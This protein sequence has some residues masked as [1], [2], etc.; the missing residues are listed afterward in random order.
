MSETNTPAEL[1][2]DQW[3]PTE[4]FFSTSPRS[5]HIRDLCVNITRNLDRLIRDPSVVQNPYEQQRLYD[6]LETQG[7][8]LTDLGI[9]PNM[10]VGTPV[11]TFESNPVTL[12]ENIAGQLLAYTNRKIVSETDIEPLVQEHGDLDTDG[13]HNMLNPKQLP[14]KFVDFA[15][16]SGTVSASYK[17]LAANPEV[18]E[19]PA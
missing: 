14:D 11:E 9:T 4:Q 6:E 16:V 8:E 10:H 17:W 12:A 2:Y 3:T 5:Y 19:P 13:P 15:V 1:R 7:E 18:Y